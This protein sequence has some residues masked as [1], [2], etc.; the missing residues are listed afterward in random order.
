MKKKQIDGS[1][2]LRKVLTMFL[3]LIFIIYGF[4]IYDKKQKNE[5]VKYETAIYDELFN[6]RVSKRVEFKKYVKFYLI[7]HTDSKTGTKNVKAIS[8]NIP[9][10]KHTII[11]TIDK[12]FEEFNG[13]NYIML[14]VN[15]SVEKVSEEIVVKVNGE[16]VIA[17]KEYCN[18]QLFEKMFFELSIDT[19][20][21]KY[22]KMKK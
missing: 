22:L 9:F 7:P 10:I 5:I 12:S 20:Y 6:I 1:K 11:K 16:S 2:E 17:N 14:P 3:T 18:K 15:F 13:N 8:E 4:T 19:V 21:E